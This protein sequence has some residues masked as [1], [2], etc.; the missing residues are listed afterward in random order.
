MSYA[1]ELREQRMSTLWPEQP[2]QRLCL[3]GIRVAIVLEHSNRKHAVHKVLSASSS[4]Y[5]SR[6]RVPGSSTK[7]LVRKH[8]RT[9]SRTR[10]GFGSHERESA[11]EYEDF[12]PRMGGASRIA[13]AM[14]SPPASSRR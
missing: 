2:P 1:A 7:S 13:L 3:F 9:A 12:A 8:G 14:L 10:T 4:T 5:P 11:S 6:I